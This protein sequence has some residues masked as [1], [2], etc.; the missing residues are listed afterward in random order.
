[1]KY[2]F[3]YIINEKKHHR[4]WP[5]NIIT[6]FTQKGKGKMQ[7]KISCIYGGFII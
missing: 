2:S 5:P 6:E 7:Q 3:Y 4:K 1:M